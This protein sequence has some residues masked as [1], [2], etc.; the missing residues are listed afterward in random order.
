[1]KKMLLSK[2][3]ISIITFMCLLIFII[4]TVYGDDADVVVSSEFVDMQFKIDSKNY[5][6]KKLSNKLDVSPEINNNITMIPFRA[7]LT[8][9]GYKI[10]WDDKTKS[11]IASD[12]KNTI[13]LSINSDTAYVNNKTQK[14]DSKPYIKNGRTL[15]PLRFV[16]EA[17]GA[18]VKWFEETKTISVSR[19][20]FYDTGSVL[21]YDQTN[22]S[23]DKRNAYVYN[24]TNI[25]TIPL[26]NQL[27]K[28]SFPYKGTILITLLESDIDS[29]NL[30]TYEDGK[31]KVLLE[32]FEIVSTL[33]F[34]DSML[35]QG[36]DREKKV[37]NIYIYDG[38]SIK[39]LKKD[40]TL[41]E[42]I[43]YENKLVINKYDSFRKYSIVTIDKDWNVETLKDDFI[44]KDKLVEDGL[45]FITSKESSGNKSPF[46]IYNGT[47]FK[48]IHDDL[49]MDLERTILFESEEYGIKYKNIL[50]AAKNV[51][52]KGKEFFVALRNMGGT[53][54]DYKLYDITIENEIIEDSKVEKTPSS[55][56][57]K[58]IKK[59]NGYIYI[60]LNGTYS[61]FR[62]KTLIPKIIMSG[63]KENDKIIE[64]T[65]SKNGMFLTLSDS[66]TINYDCDFI[67]SKIFKNQLLVQIHN[68]G[69]VIKD[70]EDYI[71][72][73]FN[74]SLKTNETELSVARDV[75]KVNKIIE[76]M[77]KLFIDVVDIDRLTDDERYTLILFDPEKDL[78]YQIKNLVIGM[79]T[80]VWQPIEGALVINGYEADIDKYKVYL[81]SDGFNEILSNF[82]SS[83]W[84]NIGDKVYTS[85]LDEDSNEINLYSIDSKGKEL[86]QRNF[87]ATKIEKALNNY[88]FINAKITNKNSPH[89]NKKI[90]YI[91]NEK[92]KKFVDVEV[93]IDLTDI[94]HFK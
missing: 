88:F 24:G 94:V 19:L 3:N 55:L 42:H 59:F 75:K 50:T 39:L 37:N 86:I 10:E 78:D 31:F 15:I 76:H 67:D 18:E 53:S 93:D 30:V 21:F 89:Y 4:N 26:K 73:I 79:E 54:D 11:I 56:P 29:Y 34:N 9:F 48:V 44:I 85:G 16:A 68:R 62:T 74:K 81:Y 92:S 27:I 61:L 36:Y 65:M 13:K 69:K 2:I 47:E 40:F 83:Y 38:I 33:E 46:S 1:M 5:T 32:N 45:L 41:G 51:S 82:Q 12:G 57:V 49:D 43:I 87:S 90:L 6:S 58:M 80:K 64:K 7:F 72:N 66:E 71:L 17:S 20:G 14:L 77:N 63:I 84:T 70:N 25:Q 91:W 22:R 35:I 28:N 8:E 23:I 52:T 60:H